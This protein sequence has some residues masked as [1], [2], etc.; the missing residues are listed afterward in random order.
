MVTQSLKILG[1]KD[2]YNNTINVCYNSSQEKSRNK[3]TDIK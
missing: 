3:I 1:V 2:S